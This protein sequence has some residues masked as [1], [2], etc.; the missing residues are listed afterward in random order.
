MRQD[1]TFTY[2]DTEFEPELLIL[3]CDGVVIDSEVISALTLIDLLKGWEIQIDVA[4]VREHFL[5]RSF[6]TVA[7]SV[8]EL[9]GVRL[10][11]Q[12][13]S[14]YR[15]RL[16]DKF[17]TDLRLVDGLETLLDHLVIPF[18]IATSSSPI[19]VSRSLHLTGVSARFA[20][21][22]FTA[23][24]VAH[25]K[26]APDLFLHVADKMGVHPDK[27]LVVEDSSVGLQAALSAQMCTVW[28]TGASH[29]RKMTKFGIEIKGFPQGPHFT[30][31]TFEELIAQV[32]S[33][34][35]RADG[36]TH[37]S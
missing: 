7:G 2:K 13:E 31:G 28:F 9:F 34:G 3:D 5:G 10:P 29:M 33:I 17:E 24:E 14:D 4:F 15:Q 32:P 35:N 6:P 30:V 12:F 18:C 36:E 20:D 8:F 37:G 22:V 21:R 16:F 19:R 27:C 23:S 25:G 26:P 11:P 1:G